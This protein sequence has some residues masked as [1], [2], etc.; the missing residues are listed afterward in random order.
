MTLHSMMRSLTSHSPQPRSGQRSQ[1]GSRAVESGT[2]GH[3]EER[4]PVEG[5]PLAS[6]AA[7]V[8]RDDAGAHAL[9]ALRHVGRVWAHLI[10]TRGGGARRVGRAGREGRCAR[11]DEQQRL[12]YTQQALVTCCVCGTEQI[13]TSRES[14]PRIEEE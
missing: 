8:A 14:P 11:G 1:E 12:A 9:A 10:G 2:G 4:S 5:A 7:H 3:V 13:S 6:P